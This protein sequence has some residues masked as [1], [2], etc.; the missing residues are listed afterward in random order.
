MLHD[1]S[2]IDG[3]RDVL[4]TANRDGRQIIKEVEESLL[5]ADFA[6]IARANARYDPDIT[7]FS[8]IYRAHA[9]NLVVSP[10]AYYLATEMELGERTSDLLQRLEVDQAA[11]DDAL[12]ELQDRVFLIFVDDGKV[13]ADETKINLRTN[14]L[15][16]ELG[17]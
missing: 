16:Y 10:L 3:I 11:G 14:C 12:R 17:S 1:L 15:R 9:R 2:G 13:W 8:R 6:D 4:L 5:A 7:G